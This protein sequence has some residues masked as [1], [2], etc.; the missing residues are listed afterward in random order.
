MVVNR[1]CARAL[2]PPIAAGGYS[3]RCTG[4]SLHMFGRQDR[5][6]VPYAGSTMLSMP[7]ETGAQFPWHRPSWYQDEGFHWHRRTVHLGVASRVDI[8]GPVAYAKSDPVTRHKRHSPAKNMSVA[9]RSLFGV[10]PACALMSESA[11]LAVRMRRSCCERPTTCARC[12]AD[13]E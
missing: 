10:R 2:E 3:K 9:H 1:C 11:C 13:H 7:T 6:W 5:T 12:L 4:R 8:P